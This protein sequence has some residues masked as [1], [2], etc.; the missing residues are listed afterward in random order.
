VRRWTVTVDPSGE[1]RATG[2][3]TDPELGHPLE[4]QPLDVTPVA[5]AMKL[6][7]RA[8]N[9]EDA[10]TLARLERDKWIRLFNRLEAAVTHHRR[11]VE[12]DG[13]LCEPESW[14]TA[15]WKARD[16]ILKDAAEG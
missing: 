7:V 16:Q 6:R 5:E 1:L 13:A 8:H 3:V 11:A 2:D 12:E 4:W 10:L 14:D 15:L 9:A